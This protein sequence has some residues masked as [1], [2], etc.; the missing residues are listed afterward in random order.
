MLGAFLVL[1]YVYYFAT[2]FSNVQI[3]VKKDDLV[4][5]N[6]RYSSNMI[7]T[8]DGR[9]FK[10]STNPLIFA[11]NAGEILNQLDEQT[12]YTVSGYGRRVPMLGLYPQITAIK[13]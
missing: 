1:F 11:F 7:G 8:T 9:V 2:R 13:K 10:V 4:K 5:A 3:T 6:G 12:S